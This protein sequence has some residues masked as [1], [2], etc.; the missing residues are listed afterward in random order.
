MADILSVT[1]PLTDRAMIPPNKQPVSPDA[2]FQLSDVTKVIQPDQQSEIQRQNNTLIERESSATILMNLLKDPSVTVGFLK[3]IDALQEFIKLLPVN[4]KSLTTEI[5][6]LFNELLISP[7]NIV[8]ELLTQELSAS[9]FKGELFDFL[10]LLAGEN[11]KPEMKFGISALLKALNGLES[12]EMILSSVAN[13]LSFLGNSLSAS[14]SLSQRLLALAEQFRSPQA[15][16]NFNELKDSTLL[17]LED[18]KSSILY[19]PKLQKIVPMIIYNLSRFSDNPSALREALGSLSIIVDGDAQ[20]EA[21]SKLLNSYIENGGESHGDSRVMNILA[22]IIGKESAI[23]EQNGSVANEN[24]ERIIHSLLSSPCNYTPLLHYIIPVQDDDLKAFAEMWIDPNAE[25]TDNKG[26]TVS[27]CIHV[28][29][30]FDID[31]IGRFEAELAASSGK[32]IMIK[33][34]CPPAYLPAFTN[35]AQEIREPIAASGY[36]LLD[37]SVDKLERQRSLMD[38]FKNLPHKRTGI[39]VTI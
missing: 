22:Q 10:R 32:D 5:E 20:R 30:V 21:L 16:D 35:L 19:S 36:R 25:S 34:F 39:D 27:D 13:N 29:M 37:I 4:N 31:G 38:V 1:T 3:N 9:S 8:E 2:D 28:L 24:I 7:E 23:Q 17:L 18:V 15:V 33:V 11:A 26:R 6:Q 12:R 14:N